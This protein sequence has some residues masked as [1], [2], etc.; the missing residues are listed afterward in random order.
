MTTVPY[1]QR[2]LVAAIAHERPHHNV[3]LEHFLPAGP[4]AQLPMVGIEGAPHVSA[5]VWTE[6]IALADRMFET[7][8]LVFAREGTRRWGTHLGAIRPVGRVWR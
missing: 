7:N 3:A 8:D 1:Q 4:F 6:G 5:I 2:G